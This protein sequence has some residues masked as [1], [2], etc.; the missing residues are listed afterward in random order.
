MKFKKNKFNSPWK[1]GVYFVMTR[2][3]T[4]TQMMIK[5][6]KWWSIDWIP[7]IKGCRGEF[8]SNFLTTAKKII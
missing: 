5:L 3:E 4:M 6:V 1:P 8:A 2:V 7:E